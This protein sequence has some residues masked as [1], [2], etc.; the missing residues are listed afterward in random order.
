M[1]FTPDAV[2]DLI[3]PVLDPVRAALGE[4]VSVVPEARSLL[5]VEPDPWFDAHIVRRVA[6]RKLEQLA[7]GDGIPWGISGSVPNS[8]IHLEV[9][10]VS[11]RICRGEPAFIPPP[12][13]SKARQRFY[14]QEAVVAQQLWYEP[15]EVPLGNVLLMWRLE[16]LEVELC[17]AIPDG[18]WKW[19]TKPRLRAVF[20]VIDD[21]LEFA[22]FEADDDDGRWLIAD[23]E[24]ETDFEDEDG[25][26]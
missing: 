26:G 22:E 4:G 1:D 10:G 8:G 25:L 24:E 5:G 13:P 7:P 21:D 12:G 6:R 14:R 18:E 16:G 3:I 2:R 15:S 11:T 17:V 19:G 20:P 23:I 9:N